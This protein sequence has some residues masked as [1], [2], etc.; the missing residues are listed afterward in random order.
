MT[1]VTRLIAPYPLLAKVTGVGALEWFEER[2]SDAI[3]PNVK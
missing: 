3:S 1:E 2:R